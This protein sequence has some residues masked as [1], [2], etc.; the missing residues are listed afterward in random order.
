MIAID[1]AFIFLKTVSG[2]ETRNW[3]FSQARKEDKRY[4]YSTIKRGELLAKL[5]VL[6]KPCFLVTKKMI[7]LQQLPS[8]FNIVGDSVS[9]N[10]S[11]LG[12]FVHIGILF[13]FY[14]NHYFLQPLSIF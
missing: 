4:E 3:R 5:V 6:Q 10:D 13:V 9:C 12:R 11:S 14:I 8:K 7:L 1:V 2:K